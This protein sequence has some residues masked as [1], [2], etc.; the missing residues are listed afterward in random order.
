MSGIIHPDVIAGRVIWRDSGMDRVIH[1]IQHGDPVLGWEGDDRL[2]VYRLRTVL[3]DVYELMRLE[4][5][6]EYRRVVATAPGDPFDDTIIIWLVENDR[7]RKPDGWSLHDEIVAH[8]TRIDDE[9]DKQRSEW[10]HEEIG[11]RLLSA[12]KKDAGY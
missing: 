10:V 11:P 5:D 3:G 6:N 9:R 8:N 4:E 7:R 2:A 12:V 1:K